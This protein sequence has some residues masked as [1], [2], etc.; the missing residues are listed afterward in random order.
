MY[1]EGGVCDR[2]GPVGGLGGTGGPGGV[3]FL[4]GWGW[5]AGI[6]GADGDRL[7][8]ATGGGTRDPIMLVVGAL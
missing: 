1:W 3:A 2:G 6:L 7:G 5:D 4:K 8:I